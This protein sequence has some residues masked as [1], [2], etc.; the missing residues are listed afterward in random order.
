[1]SLS[2]ILS[3]NV[4]PNQVPWA[5]FSANT[6]NA[7]DLSANNILV[8]DLS[9]N[10]INLDPS[11]QLTVENALI[12]NLSLFG[13]PDSIGSGSY[14]FTTTDNTLVYATGGTTG[15]FS[16]QFVNSADHTIFQIY[17][18]GEVETQTN[19][20]DDDSGNMEV[21]SI[22]VRGGVNGTVGG[23]IKKRAV[24][25]TND[26]TTP[27]ELTPAQLFGGIIQ[28][29]TSNNL[30]TPQLVTL[31]LPTGQDITL[32]LSEN[33]NMVPG[34]GASF[35]CMLMNCNDGQIQLNSDTTC[36]LSVLQTISPSNIIQAFTAKMLYFVET[37]FNTWI[38]YL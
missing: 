13:A 26:I 17:A 14:G 18:N 33:Y 37:G 9:A 25:T 24:F 38:V 32:Y 15:S 19:V 21:G 27:V 22:Y 6:I 31:I 28:C 10:N 12:H 36:T 5:N 30:V 34:V 20:L 11:G 35:S 29:D 7:N 8:N 4:T 1:M 3:S 2:D 16:H 23:I